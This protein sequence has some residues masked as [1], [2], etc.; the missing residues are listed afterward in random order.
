MDSL[1]SR[2]MC[3]SVATCPIGGL[4]FNRIMCRSVATCPIGGQF[5]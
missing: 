4:L 2:I 3:R 5:N 1:I